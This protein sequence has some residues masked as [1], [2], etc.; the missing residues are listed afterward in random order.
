MQLDRDTIAS[1]FMKEVGIPMKFAFKNEIEPAIRSSFRSA[2]GM[3]SKTRGTATTNALQTLMAQLESGLAGRQ[4]Q[5]TQLNAQLL[6]SARARQLEAIPYA[7]AFAQR[8]LSRAGALMTAAGP[9]Q[10]YAQSL[11]SAKT[12]EF[13]RTRP[14]ASPWLQLG[15]QYVAQPHNEIVGIQGQAGPDWLGAGAMLGAAAFLA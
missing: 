5:G 9:F 7:E 12:S 3:W 13:L 15:M 2:G 4:W 6:E 8:P 14:E 11:L 1:D 10:Q